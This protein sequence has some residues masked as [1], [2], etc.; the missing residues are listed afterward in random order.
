MSRLGEGQYDKNDQV[1]LNLLTSAESN[2]VP[3]A[4]GL[5]HSCNKAELFAQL[6]NYMKEKEERGEVINDNEDEGNFK[7]Y[8][9]RENIIGGSLHLINT[10]VTNVGA[11]TPMLISTAL[12]VLFL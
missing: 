3:E 5:T 2:K 8:T 11:L 10:T 4:R 6:T 1:V 12:S 9:Y 7:S